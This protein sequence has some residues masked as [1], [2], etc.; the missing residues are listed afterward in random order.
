LKTD[1]NNTIKT[2]SHWQNFKFGLVIKSVCVGVISGLIVVAFRYALEEIGFFSKQVYA[3]LRN[4]NYYLCLWIPLL[5]VLAYIVGLIIIKEPM[6]KGS[7]IPQVE[8]VLLRQLD[9]N[10]WKVVLGKFVGGVLC[11]GAG[12]SLGREGPSIQLGAAMGQGFSKVFK[13]P[14]IEEKF[15]I[16]GGA[17]AGLAAAF[18][19]PL[20]GMIFALEE[21]H[22]NFSPLILLAA[23][24]AALTGDLVSKEF[25]GINPVLNFRELPVMPL[26]NYMYL[27]F[28]GFITGLTGVLFNY[29]L[30]KTQDLY[31]LIKFIPIRF[32]LAIPFLAACLMGLF[33]PQVQGGGHDLI[34]SMVKD[35]FF[36]GTLIVLLLAKFVFTMVSFG[37]G[38]PGGIFLPMLAIGAIIG[39][40][41][42]NIITN[43]FNL[44]MDFKNNFIILA[45]AGY[46]TAV[47]RAPVTGIVLITEMTGSFTHLLS[48]SMVCVISY[49]TADILK[50]KPVYESLL[51]RILKN[52]G[53]NEFKGDDSIKVILEIAVPMGCAIEG[54]R[55][56]EIKWP[57]KCLLVGVRRGNEELIPNGNT[58]I[59]AGDY[60]ITLADEQRAPGIEGIL[61]NLADSNRTLAEYESR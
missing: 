2:I 43:I 23:A 21:V 48:L 13:R 19:A 58:K 5:L 45:M 6:T 52:A 60:L 41:Y 56:K 15:L 8:G 28:L 9:M 24:S 42:G 59:C 40:L 34:V 31:G 53:D 20:A 36:I 3:F 7:G 49:L 18:N 11:I 10:W 44:N 33:L 4:N 57:E 22:K 38:A 39:N 29:T 54:K 51:D 30:L 37:S 61:L 35:N 32:R 46:F 26:S 16:T 25:F 50:S 12:L 47:V 1:G 55:V 14:K 27:I 17:S